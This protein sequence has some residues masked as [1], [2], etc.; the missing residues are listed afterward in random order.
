[1]EKQVKKVFVYKSIDGDSGQSLYTNSQKA[2]S[3][4]LRQDSGV[5]SQKKFLQY[6]SVW[7]LKT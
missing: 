1:M 3:K 5:C 4:S 6:P 2:K 7:G